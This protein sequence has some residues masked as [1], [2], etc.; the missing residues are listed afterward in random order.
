MRKVWE[1]GGGERAALG[2]DFSNI[3]YFRCF[4]MVPVFYAALRVNLFSTQP[5]AFLSK[6]QKGNFDHFGSVLP[7]KT[8]RATEE[9]CGNRV[10]PVENLSFNVKNI[11]ANKKKITKRSFYTLRVLVGDAAGPDPLP[12]TG[13][14]TVWQGDGGAFGPV[15]ASF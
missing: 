2:E 14:R 8:Q 15:L 10:C 3:T 1:P 11:F 7:I 12:W 5:G 9:T 6:H 13:H 4:E